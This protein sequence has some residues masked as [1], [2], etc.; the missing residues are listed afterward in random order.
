MTSLGKM[1]ES[2]THIIQSLTDN[3]KDPMHVGEVMACWTYLTFVE[4]IIIFEEV[5]LNTT[6][7]NSLKELYND[8]LKIATSH[9]KELSERMRQEGAPLP[10]PP[11]HKPKSDPDAIPLGAK[12][13]EDELVNTLNI[14]FVYAADQCAVSASQ[15]L[16]T[17]IGLMFLNFQADKLSLGFKAKELMKKKGWLKIPPYY[18]P[19][20]APN[21]NEE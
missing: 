3:H 14:N 16:R 12:F 15:C 17:D 19:P 4:N 20:G 2:A 6:T 8:A 7:D 1:F 10:N 21:Q 13:T 18:N 9:K 11:Q 5:G